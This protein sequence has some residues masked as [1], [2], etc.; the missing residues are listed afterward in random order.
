MDYLEIMDLVE[1]SDLSSN[2]LRALNSF[3]VDLLKARRERDALRVKATLKVG[4]TVTLSGLRPKI[5]NGT[6]ATVVSVQRT[7]ATIDHPTRGRVTVP[8]SCITRS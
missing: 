3:I 5:L 8:L 1:E 2:E 7:R 6:T 4:D